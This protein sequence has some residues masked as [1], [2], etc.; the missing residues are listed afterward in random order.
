MFYE[1]ND[2]KVLYE[3][4]DKNKL[5]LNYNIPNQPFPFEKNILNGGYIKIPFKNSKGIINPDLIISNNNE[6]YKTENLY[7]AKCLLWVLN[8]TKSITKIT[9]NDY[10]KKRKNGI[11]PW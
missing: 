8:I 1:N 5:I 11:N 9:K 3:N 4:N 10:H 6:K 7:V 2:N